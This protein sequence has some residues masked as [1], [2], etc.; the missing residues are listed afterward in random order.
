MTSPKYLL[1]L[2][3]VATSSWAHVKSQGGTDLWA[4][5][6]LCW[7]ATLKPFER[8]FQLVEQCSAV[9]QGILPMTQ[10]FVTTTTETAVPHWSVV[11]HMGGPISVSKT[12]EPCAF[13]FWSEHQKD[14]QSHGWESPR[15]GCLH[16]PSVGLWKGINSL[17]LR[18]QCFFPLF[19]LIPHHQVCS[20]TLPQSSPVSPFKEDVHIHACLHTDLCGK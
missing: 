8:T 15:G 1:T 14:F 3:S 7:N 4:S 10:R 20:Q 19:W 2:R 13:S 6:P 11:L 16:I 18:S 9:M 12:G 5:P 17:F